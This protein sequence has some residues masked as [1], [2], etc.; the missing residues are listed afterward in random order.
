MTEVA[1]R[2]AGDVARV[3]V[4]AAV[5]GVSLLAVQRDH[6][7][8]FE[9]DLFRIVNDLPGTIE[10]LVKVVM[11]LGNVWATVAAVALALALRIPRLWLRVGLGGV[12]A[13]FAAKAVKSLIERPR[14]AGFLT[15][16]AREPASGLGFVS[17]HTA[18]AAALATVGA[19]HAPRWAR[20]AMWGAVLLVGLARVYVGA[21]LPM[22][23]VGGAALGWVLGSLV[24]LAV[25]V[26]HRAPTSD[27][28]A[29]VL[30]ARGWEAESVH[31]VPGR[32]A[33]SFPFIATGPAGRQFVKLLD[34]ERRDRDWI[35]RVARV[36]VVRDIRDLAVMS[37]EVAQA[38]HEAAMTL[39][40]REAG[41]RAPRVSAIVR[42]GG[43]AWLVEDVVGD[44][45]LDRLDGPPG[46]TVLRAVWEQVA[47]LHAAGLAHRD[48]VAGNIV[49]DADGRPW[50]VD[51]AHA[52][53]GATDAQ[54]DADVA[55]LLTSTALL[56]G[57][58]RAV[59]AAASVI[60]DEQFRRV[61]AAL[62]PLTL[63]A[64][65]RR[66]LRSA[67]GLFDALVA[68]VTARST[69]EARALAPVV[70]R[71][72]AAAL[73]AGIGAGIGLVVIAGPGAVA[74]SLVAGPWRWYG[75]L[76]L[77]VFV[78][79]LAGGAL[80]NAAAGTRVASGRAATIMGEANV[81]AVT[82]GC[83]PQDLHAHRLRRL[84]LGPADAGALAAAVARVRI[85]LAVPAFVAAVLAALV[86]GVEIGLPTRWPWLAG[87]AVVS[88][89]AHLVLIRR[90]GRASSGAPSPTSPR[91]ARPS[92]PARVRWPMIAVAVAEPVMGTLVLVAAEKACDGGASVALL[93]AGWTA[94]AVVAHL[95]WGGPGLAEVV[96]VVVLAV[97]GLPV[98]TAVAAVLLSRMLTYW[99]PALGLSLVL[100]ALRRRWFV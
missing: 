52:T 46:D 1:E 6:L 79:W 57:S 68:A 28:A 31:R 26:P 22:D 45:A 24:N 27:D 10:S 9:R 37:D 54:L 91:H 60:G 23:I 32:A 2:S 83:A 5:L 3:V 7:T 69:G 70:P 59:D 40:A 43:R 35:H 49:V 18:V 25:G 11:Q 71:R 19:P 100:P 65:T 15:I 96:G 12:G 72:R 98:P 33:G 82:R 13:W 21:H 51:F 36:L 77:A 62:A 47:S 50:L 48:L 67:P 75:G 16:I 86:G 41:C 29:A 66:S 81:A 87:L 73:T 53:S 74:D 78:W 30:A 39:L 64:A 38:E 44:A 85:Q 89:A 92:R 8:T 90:S 63:T 14:P 56:V 20:R 55:E 84:G 88:L 4:G 58:E 94:L 93:A 42:T 61:L 99:I 17:G 95:A 97:G 76:L 34:P 80:V